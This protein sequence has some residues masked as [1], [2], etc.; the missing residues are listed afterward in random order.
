[1]ILD[2]IN[3]ISILFILLIF[4]IMMHETGHLIMALLCKIPVEIFSIGFGKVLLKKKIKGIEFRLSLIPFGGYC[5]LYGETKKDLNGFLNQR[6]SKKFLV[7]VAG[8]TVNFII[9]CLCYYFNYKDIFYGLKFDLLFYKFALLKDI[10][11]QIVLITFNNTN[12]I[13]SQL[14][15][16][17]IGCAIFNL[18]PIP[19]LDGG[20]LVY[21]WLEKVWKEKFSIYYE[22]MNK[23]SFYL[24]IYLQIVFIYFYWLK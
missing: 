7:L 1:M 8:V 4:S 19:A 24:L 21:I 9:A 13:L 14:S 3:N 5:Q 6:Y 20:H 22:R 2:I 12:L 15:L 17:N 11:H 16:I 18:L 23:I 10:Q